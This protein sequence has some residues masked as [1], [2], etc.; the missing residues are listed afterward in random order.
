MPVSSHLIYNDAVLYQSVEE[1][2]MPQLYELLRNASG[3]TFW[4]YNYNPIC[5]RELTVRYGDTSFTVRVDSE[6]T[7]VNPDTESLASV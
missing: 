4:H 7:K 3:I 6:F 2:H 1:M 5:S